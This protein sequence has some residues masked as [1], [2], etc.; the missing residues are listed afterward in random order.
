MEIQI[1]NTAAAKEAIVQLR[2]DYQSRRPVVKGR[3]RSTGGGPACTILLTNPDGRLRFPNSG[4][5][6]KSLSI[7]ADGSWVEF[8][9]A[10]EGKSVAIGDAVIE[11]H[12]NSTTGALKA[13]KAMT[14]FW[15]D[16]AKIDIATPGR[17]SVVGGKLTTSGGNAVS[18]T[19]TADIRP[20]GI[21]CTANQITNLRVG[22]MQNALAGT[23]RERIWKTPSIAWNAGVAAGTTVTVPKMIRMQINRPATGNDSAA[24]VQ[25]LYDR[26]G[27]ADTLDAN[28]LQPPTGCSGSAQATSYDTPSTGAPANLVLP[29]QDGTGTIVGNVTYHPASVKL[30]PSFLTWCVIFDTSTNEFTVLRE[31]AWHVTVDAFTAGVQRAT[32]DA[33]DR[34]PTTMPVL[35]PLAN[36]QTNDPANSTQGPLGADTVTFS[37]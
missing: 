23:T 17:Y 27:V 18:F 4:D 10:G 1:D 35:S 30:G 25:P 7:P 9:V 8:Q 31:R 21:D 16:N 15:F 12:C 26:P 22:I 28:S 32:V 20:A 19:A 6:T 24:S 2:T 11:A 5:T 3:I 33:A 14:V 34:A 13:S 29:A 37:R 36:T